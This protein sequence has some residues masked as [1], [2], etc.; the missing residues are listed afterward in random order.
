ML[1]GFTS[2]R[3]R[4]Y[5]IPPNASR[6]GSLSAEVGRALVPRH[7]GFDGLIWSHSRIG[8][9]LG[10][11]EELDASCDARLTA[12]EAGA[13]EG[14]NHL[15]DRGWADTEM[16]LHVGFGRSAAEHVRVRVDEGQVLALLFGEAWFGGA[17]RLIFNSSVDSS[18]PPTR[19]PR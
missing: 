7:R 11:N 10:S 6:G 5:C 13:F 8:R 4:Q 2:A 12:N 1:L 3:V 15:M 14:E 9:V 19:R 18:G 17:W 16:A